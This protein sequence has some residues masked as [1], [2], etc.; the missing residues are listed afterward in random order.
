MVD[1]ADNSYSLFMIDNVDNAYSLLMIKNVKN[2]HSYLLAGNT[3][4]VTISSLSIRTSETMTTLRY[5]VSI[6]LPV[7]LTQGFTQIMYI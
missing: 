3:D 1:N 5:I 6:R 2:V 4:Y 7:M